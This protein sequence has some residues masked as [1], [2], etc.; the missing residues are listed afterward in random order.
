MAEINQRIGFEAAGA[1]RTLRSL[2]KAIGAA[3]AALRAFDRTASRRGGLKSAA[4]AMTNFDRQAKKADKTTKSLGNTLSNTGRKG[5]SAGDSLTISWQ[6]FGRV[7]VTQGI[8]RTLNGI[9]NAVGEAADEVARFQITTA[10]IANITSEGASS[11]GELGRSIEELSIQLGRPIAEVAEASMEALQNDLGTTAETMDLLAGTANDLALFTGS[12]LTSSINSLSSIMKSYGLAT[13][14][15]ADISDIFAVAIDKGRIR[16]DELESRLGTVVPLTSTLGIGF[17]ETAAAAAS[18]TLSGLNSQTA[19]TQLRNVLNKLISPGNELTAVFDQLGVTSGVDLIQRFGGLQGALQALLGA[20]NNDTTA[21]AKLFGT[22]RGRLGVLNLSGNAFENLSNIME[23]MADRAGKAAEGARA[24]DQVT[25]RQLQKE[26]QEALATVRQL[27]SAFNEAKL[28]ALRFF[29]IQTGSLGKIVDENLTVVLEDLQKRALAT[30]RESAAEIQKLG[31]VE[32]GQ[33]GALLDGDTLQLF[34]ATSRAAQR[35]ATEQSKV[36]TQ[37][38]FVK[39]LI[40]ANTQAVDKFTEKA[41]LAAA[42]GLLGGISPEAVALVNSTTAAVTQL[43]EQ[44]R[45]ASAEE[46]AGLQRRIEL[47]RTLLQ[48]AI[49]LQTVEA[50]GDAASLLS[51]QIDTAQ[52]VLKARA[53]QLILEDRQK[54][55]AA[56]LEEVE[57]VK[58]QIFEE[59]AKKL[60]GVE[61][62]SDDANQAI[63]STPD[64]SINA[65]AAISQMR[66]LESAALAAARA[67]AGANSRGTSSTVLANKGRRIPFF[68]SGGQ[69]TRGTDTILAGLS[70]GETVINA[71]QSRNFFA[72]LQAMN[73]GQRPQFREQ[74]GPVTNIGDINVSVQSSSPVPS[75]TGRD[76]GNALRREIRRGNLNLS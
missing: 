29:N 74:G 68:Q 12:D 56:E 71:R 64:P 42:P 63:R 40:D 21:F 20:V 44:T 17:E 55:N 61:N 35:L 26:M 67:V 31:R 6:T 48:N 65:S 23:A 3:D 24:I 49:G 73:S 57:R 62:A 60:G 14:E 72:Q 36:N 46:I 11:V 54:Q 22:I 76:I 30:A 27:G 10:Q 8:V 13:S 53:S 1:I 28:A 51:R 19:M 39:G 70:P 58:G 32:R 15:A 4:T 47:R 45:Q 9:I 69:P 50:D 43:T 59:Q 33:A 37:I 25:A 5:K 16:L 52:Q 66:Q 2:T 7:L 18:L 38:E 75:Q 41:R 34:E